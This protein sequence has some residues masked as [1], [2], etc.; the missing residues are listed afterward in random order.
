MD[1]FK[2]ATGIF[3]ILVSVPFSSGLL[4]RRPHLECKDVVAKAIEKHENLCDAVSNASSCQHFNTVF[5]YLNFF[6]CSTPVQ[7]WYK[8]TSLVVLYI[9]VI[10]FLFTIVGTTTDDFF[11]PSLQSVSKSLKLS[12][13]VAGVTLLAFGNGAP[14]I[15]SSIAALDS[16]A[17]AD[18][19]LS[20]GALI[21]AAL[22][23][24]CFISGSVWTVASFKISERPFLRD[25]AFLIATIYWVFYI[26]WMRK[27]DWI[28]ALMML[29]FYG[30]YCL[31]VVIGRIV[32]LWL[33][34]S[35]GS[36]TVQV[37][38]GVQSDPVEQV[39]NFEQVDAIEVEEHQVEVLFNPP[40]HSDSPDIFIFTEI[41]HRLRPFSLEQFHSAT[42]I[43]KI[44]LILQ[45]P[46]LFAL[47]LI[48]P[49]I[50]VD[51]TGNK[52]WCK[53]L[54][55]WHLMV[56][57]ALISFGL[58]FAMDEFIPRFPVF[59]IL[60]CISFVFC[61]TIALKTERG[62]APS[63]HFMFSILGFCTAI[64]IIYSVANE[65]IGILQT[66]GVIL[67]I[68][69]SILGLTVLAWGNS[70]PDFVADITLAR[71]GAPR[72]GISACY[73]GPLLN[74]LVGL[75]LPYLFLSLKSDSNA[76]EFTVDPVVKVLIVMVLFALSVSIIAVPMQKFVVKK[77]FGV[78]LI[79]YY[80]VCLTFWFYL[81]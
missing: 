67:N 22:F 12:E 73:A 61:L 43:S 23:I 6:Y 46:I 72:I 5:N 21:G 2:I 53:W 74:I 18:P 62:R 78:A 75:G 14:D 70:V 40:T 4:L 48:I 36:E 54:N 58:H 11:C 69:S 68:S 52:F 32:N 26:V 30:I 76:F 65:V 50:K 13:N 19:T 55:I 42:K 9:A 34:K 38:A 45:G 59:L 41:W 51:E 47:T 66:L 81:N 10:I 57:P 56:C 31:V 28:N 27:F 1:A 7:E 20:F 39:S 49:L 24:T 25:T 3:F 77:V 16:V 33:R 60:M 80:F 79:V 17:S 29:V 44:L 63:F 71:K 37:E 8:T 64:V 35:T 15:F